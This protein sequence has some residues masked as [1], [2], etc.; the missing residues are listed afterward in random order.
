[1]PAGKFRPELPHVAGAAATPSAAHGAAG[2]TAAAVD[3]AAVSLGAVVKMTIV[4]D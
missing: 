3:D 2:A 1:M 4:A